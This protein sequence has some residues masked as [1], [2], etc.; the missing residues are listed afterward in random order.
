MDF[1]PQFK[2]MFSFC[3]YTLYYEVHLVR[4]LDDPLSGV[5]KVD[6][7]P[8]LSLCFRSKT[9]LFSASVPSWHDVEC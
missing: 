2:N 1:E 9:R 4:I 7:E 6:F 8:L 3:S 5:R